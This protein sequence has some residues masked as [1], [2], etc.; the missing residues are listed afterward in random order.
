MFVMFRYLGDKKSIFDR[1]DEAREGHLIQ[2]LSCNGTV[3]KRVGKHVVELR[4]VNP[5]DIRV[6]FHED[7]NKLF[8]ARLAFKSE[9]EENDQDEDIQKSEEMIIG[10]L[11]A[12]E[13][14]AL[15]EREG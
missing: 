15:S 5:V 6:Y 8:F 2:P 13:C 9:Y 7:G 4:I 14:G 11:K 1:L 3:I 12:K 10:M